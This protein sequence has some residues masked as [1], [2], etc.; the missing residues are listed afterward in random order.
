[1]L[2]RRHF[3]AISAATASLAI[4]PTSAFAASATD[5]RFMFI[6]LR[7]GMDG[8]AAVPTPNDTLYH[9]LRPSIGVSADEAL[10]LDDTFAL[11]PALG[12]LHEMFSN[13]EATIF[14]NISSPN[15][16]RSHFEA[17]RHLEQG[18][19]TLDSINTGWLARTLSAHY[20]DE[21]NAGIA[22]SQALQTSFLGADNVL[23]WA[24]SRIPE[25]PDRFLDQLD[26]LYAASPSLQNALAD[27]RAANEIA[28]MQT[29]DELGE[30]ES[31]NSM[32]AVQSGSPQDL[33]RSAGQFLAL[34]DGPR[35][36]MMD[37]GGWDTHDNQVNDLN[38]QL[39]MLDQS[40]QMLKSSLGSAWQYTSVL[41][42]TEFGRTVAENG[43]SG[44]DHGTAGA[45]F[46]LGGAVAGGQVIADWRGLTNDELWD[47]R[48]L[49]PT[50]D[51]RSVMK[52]ILVDHLGMT[53][54]LAE[55]EVFPNSDDAVKTQ[56]LFL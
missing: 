5:P 4:A 47:G 41:V 40:L 9:S 34:D 36:A 6:F 46:L 25:A 14:H 21:E 55:T 56:G 43:T 20:G 27:G 18:G 2:N 11:H 35:I 44:T 15:R 50:T 1:M 32:V 13:G 48:D 30:D 53:L 39:P 51:A 12:G 52:A 49:P 45:A 17:M 33:A 3:L 42:M 7:G 8:L 54:D 23:T 37:I 28:A 22:L 10:A 19:D 24:P 31:N 38:Q 16:E 29:S 26:G